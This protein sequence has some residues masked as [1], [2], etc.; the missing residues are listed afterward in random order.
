MASTDIAG[1]RIRRYLDDKNLTPEQFGDLCGVSGMTIYR[2]AYPDI[3]KQPRNGYRRDTKWKV[4]R[5]LGEEPSTL[6]PP[7]PRKRKPGGPRQG[8]NPHA[9]RAIEVPA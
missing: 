8:Q 1:L 4:A 3:Y 6:W 2:I 5:E 9:R 7:M